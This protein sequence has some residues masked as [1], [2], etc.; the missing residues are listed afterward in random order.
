M[1][2]HSTLNY[3]IVLLILVSVISGCMHSE[4]K[5]NDT[6][7]DRMNEQI[8][9]GQE[10]VFSLAWGTKSQSNTNIEQI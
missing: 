5:I 9:S 2:K 8:T 1:M 7:S 3:A 4:K 10:P 6:P